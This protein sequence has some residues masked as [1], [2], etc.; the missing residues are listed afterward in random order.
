MFGTSSTT[1]PKR[2]AVADQMFSQTPSKRQ[3]FSGT[4]S[5]RQSLSFSFNQSYNDDSG[6]GEGRKEDVS[7]SDVSNPTHLHRSEDLRSDDSSTQGTLDHSQIIQSERSLTSRATKDPPSPQLS[8]RIE[9]EF[10]PL[11]FKPSHRNYPLP[12]SPQ[13]PKDNP[14]PTQYNIRTEYPRPQRNES[15][16]SPKRFRL[17][18]QKVLHTLPMPS[19]PTPQRPQTS[20]HSQGPDVSERPQEKANVEKQRL[21]NFWSLGSPTNDFSLL[22]KPPNPFPNCSKSES[23]PQPSLPKQVVQ[24][25]VHNRTTD[26]KP[27]NPV[28]PHPS[29]S[30]HRKQVLEPK[31]SIDHINSDITPIRNDSS[32][33]LHFTQGIQTIDHDYING[34]IEKSWESQSDQ[35]AVHNKF[36]EI[37]KPASAERKPVLK[38]STVNNP[39]TAQE[40]EFEKALEISFEHHSNYNLEKQ[41]AQLKREKLAN[42]TF[43]GIKLA[44]CE[45]SMHVTDQFVLPKISLT[46][47][48]RKTDSSDYVLNLKEMPLQSKHND[49]SS[50][51]DIIEI[52]HSSKDEAEICHNSTQTPKTEPKMLPQTLSQS[53][54]GSLYITF[55]HSYAKQ[56]MYYSMIRRAL[57]QLKIATLDTED[58]SNQTDTSSH[59]QKEKG[60]EDLA[61]DN[62]L[63]QIGDISLQYDDIIIEH[64]TIESEAI[65]DEDVS[66]DVERAAV[67]M[68]KVDEVMNDVPRNVTELDHNPII[69]TEVVDESEAKQGPSSQQRAEFIIWPD[70]AMF[71]EK[72]PP[73]DYNPD[74]PL[75]GEE[76]FSRPSYS[77]S[78]QPMAKFNAED[79]VLNIPRMPAQPSPQKPFIPVFLSQKPQVEALSIEPAKPF[80]PSFSSQ[81]PQVIQRETKSLL[82]YSYEES[83]MR[84]IEELTSQGSD[85]SDKVQEKTTTDTSVTCDIK[86]VLGILKTKAS[87]FVMRTPAKQIQSKNAIPQ[88]IFE[89]AATVELKPQTGCPP[90]S[91]TSRLHENKRSTHKIISDLKSSHKRNRSNSLELPPID[92]KRTKFLS[93]TNADFVQ[94]CDTFSDPPACNPSTPYKVNPSILEQEKQRKWRALVLEGQK[95]KAAQ[96]KGEDVDGG[97]AVEDLMEDGGMEEEDQPE[98]KKGGCKMV[99]RDEEV[100]MDDEMPTLEQLIESMDE[101]ER[102]KDVRKGDVT[103]LD[104]FEDKTQGDAPLVTEERL[105][106]QGHFP[107]GQTASTTQQPPSTNWGRASPKIEPLTPSSWSPKY[108]LTQQR[109]VQALSG[110]SSQS[111]LDSQGTITQFLQNQTP[112]NLSQMNQTSLEHSQFTRE[113]LSQKTLL[114]QLSTSSLDF[115]LSGDKPALLDTTPGKLF[116]VEE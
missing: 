110:V 71:F 57:Q 116:I 111:V 15:H 44:A 6:Y 32:H 87:P 25:Q 64:V 43:V 50:S 53:L 19:F 34:R 101:E 85:I 35:K 109:K 62:L 84:Q 47:Q 107:S 48:I 93:Q 90:F 45:Q 55:D 37:M 61:R 11:P 78:K 69:T 52:S 79:L 77:S 108:S 42:T 12:P 106:S 56:T 38:R 31:S 36:L 83:V 49:P 39:E 27:P 24:V 114:S 89:T 66:E 5:K 26:H 22:L 23:T 68:E 91:S 112:L 63:T 70:E 115:E 7:W 29:H 4:P 98:E 58:A 81:K 10:T 54:L 76:G 14:P 99:E 96:E 104:L 59:P 8:H 103:T 28:K 60:N 72:L 46:N 30:P 9:P 102:G 1:R 73:Q 40:K 95:S 3:S 113:E 21:K 33:R 94:N 82:S 88:P 86:P 20:Q 18:P 100:A 2:S 74:T 92:N 16:S 41:G 67:I 75:E 51:Q 97:S 13:I 65:I 80:I 105:S 17:S